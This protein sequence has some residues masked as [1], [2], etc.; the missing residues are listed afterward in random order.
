LDDVVSSRPPIHV[1]VGV[2]RR[3]GGGGGPGLGPGGHVALAL[4][5]ALAL[6]AAGQAWAVAPPFTKAFGGIVQASGQ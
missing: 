2:P 4:A 1:V 3:G 6:A 5:L